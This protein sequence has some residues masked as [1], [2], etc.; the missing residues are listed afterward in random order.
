MIRQST[1]WAVIVIVAVG[2]F[3]VRALFLVPRRVT[4]PPSP[5]VVDGLRMIPPAAFAALVI[6]ALLRPDGPVDL[7]TPGLLAGVLAALTAWRTRNIAAT[8]AIGLVSVV[9]LERVPGVG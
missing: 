7:L 2:T 9:V 8:I 6:P 1:M 3:L 5:A 4:E